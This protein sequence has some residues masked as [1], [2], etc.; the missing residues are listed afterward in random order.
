MIHD[1]IKL[2]DAAPMIKVIATPQKT[3]DVPVSTPCIDSS[4]IQ[5]K[6]NNFSIIRRSLVSAVDR[7]STATIFM[8]T[9]NRKI[10]ATEKNKG[11]EK[12]YCSMDRFNENILHGFFFSF[13][14][15]RFMNK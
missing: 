3:S 6:W 12:N 13:F 10:A 5:L 15:Q 14:F 9:N 1:R 2:H 4:G 8:S 11:V 7:D